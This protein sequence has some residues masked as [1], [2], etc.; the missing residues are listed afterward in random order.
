MK[1][2][3]FITKTFLDREYPEKIYSAISLRPEEKIRRKDDHKS[4]DCIIGG[5]QEN[6]RPRWTHC[7]SKCS[8]YLLNILEYML[9]DLRGFIFP[10]KR[11]MECFG[12]SESQYLEEYR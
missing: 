8:L 5:H 7:R 11:G 9:A 1:L 6:Q 2:L 12:E 3:K 10:F 4:P